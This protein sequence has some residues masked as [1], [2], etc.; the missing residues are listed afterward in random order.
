MGAARPTPVI[1]ILFSSGAIVARPSLGKLIMYAAVPV[2]AAGACSRQVTT[3]PNY[4]YDTL[5]INSRITI[6]NLLEPGEKTCPSPTR[7]GEVGK[8]QR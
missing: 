3:E 2:A 5:H 4:V 7:I 6:Q 1:T 8:L